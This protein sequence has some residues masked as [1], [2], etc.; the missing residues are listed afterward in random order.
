MLEG[1]SRSHLVQPLLEQG[2]V[3]LVEPSCFHC[4]DIH[5]LDYSLFLPLPA[6]NILFTT[7]LLS[8]LLEVKPAWASPWKTHCPPQARQPLLPTSCC[9]RQDFM[10]FCACLLPASVHSAG[11]CWPRTTC[12]KA[13]CCRSE[14]ASHACLPQMFLLSELIGTTCT[15]GSPEDPRPAQTEM[16]EIS[17]WLQER[18]GSGCFT[19]KGPPLNHHQHWWA[20]PTGEML[21]PPPSKDF[22]PC[23]GLE[24]TAASPILEAW[25]L[26][27]R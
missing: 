25:G 4:K 3:E 23:R 19:S 15:T 13:S 21:P 1:T 8:I 20:Q 6:A 16:G 27:H 2:H 17:T 26:R 12:H 10:W 22:G 9:F 24:S 14:P 11:I 7:R 5:L 18:V